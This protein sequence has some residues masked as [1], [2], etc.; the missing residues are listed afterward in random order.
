MQ[1]L[2]RTATFEYGHTVW[3]PCAEGRHG[4]TKGYKVGSRMNVGDACIDAAGVL[5]A[6]SLS[7]STVP[8]NS[9]SSRFLTLD[10]SLSTLAHLIEAVR[11]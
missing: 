4:H 7:Y 9:S 3:V 11:L 8:A 6:H 2:A 5:D 1:F 10:L